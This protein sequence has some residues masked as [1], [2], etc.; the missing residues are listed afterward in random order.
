MKLGRSGKLVL[1]G[2]V[3]LAVE[4]VMGYLIVSFFIRQQE[5]SISNG[6][7]QTVHVIKTNIDLLL[8]TIAGGMLRNGALFRINGKYLTPSRYA[9]YL[10]RDS[11][12][13]NNVIQSQRWIP[14]I[15]QSERSQFI[16]FYG[17]FYDNEFDIRKIVF[18]PN[19]SEFVISPISNKTEYYPFALAEPPFTATV[20]GGDFS[21][22]SGFNDPLLLSPVTRT[23]RT[24]IAIANNDRNFGLLLYSTVRSDVPP[25]INLSVPFPPVNDTSVVIGLVSVLLVPQILVRK[26]ADLAG[27]GLEHYQL[28][29][30]IEPPLQL[31]VL[32]MVKVPL[33]PLI[34]S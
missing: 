2:V 30:L 10:Q 18:V 3:V 31:K 34:Q 19:T 6:Q 25:V 7:R 32:F 20:M 22:F 16:D 1:L 15:T 12:L 11:N 29:I 13:L 4:I 23:N 26:A 5:N 14:R 33:Y 9:E 21:E 27:V 17:G 24:A 28:L 8:Q